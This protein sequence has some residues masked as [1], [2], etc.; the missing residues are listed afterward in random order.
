MQ[1]RSSQMKGDWG[2]GEEG[3]GEKKKEKRAGKTVNCQ[4]RNLGRDSRSDADA[5][6]EIRVGKKRLSRARGEARVQLR[7]TR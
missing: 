6:K 3:R 4:A 7:F 2:C 5:W 1:L